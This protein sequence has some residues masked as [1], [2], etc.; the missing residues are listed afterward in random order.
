LILS[1]GLLQS[2]LRLEYDYL[3][4]ALGAEFAHEH[5]KGFSENGAINLYDAGQI[6]KLRERIVSLKSG[7]IASCI[8]SLPYKCP[9]APYEASILISDILVSN[10]Q[11]T[12]LVLIFTHL[13]QVHCQQL[14]QM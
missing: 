3:V 8:T 12:Q 13:H 2:T 5:V 9:P 7:R 11:E 14:E 6:P 10:V 4:I 1:Q